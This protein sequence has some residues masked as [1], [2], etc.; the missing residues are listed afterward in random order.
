MKTQIPLLICLVAGLF[1]GLQYFI[2]AAL[3]IYNR[4]NDYIQVVT[5]FALVLGVVNVIHRHVGR[6]QPRGPE[7][8]RDQDWPFSLAALAGLVVMLAAGFITQRGPLFQSLFNSILLPVQSSMFALLAFYLASA[9]FRAFRGRDPVVGPM[10]AS[11]G[12][13]DESQPARFA[14]ALAGSHAA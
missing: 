6:M 3:P 10:L 13:I 4:V 1:M 7:R 9:A 11:R 8:K 2:P 14:G 5:A 12:L